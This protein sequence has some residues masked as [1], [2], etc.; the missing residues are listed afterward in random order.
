MKKR[1]RERGLSV[2]SVM[3]MAVTAAVL[4]M[5]LAVLIRLQMDVRVKDQ[6]ANALALSNELT[7]GVMNIPH[8]RVE[9]KPTQT[10]KPTAV[11]GETVTATP[12]P[13]AAPTAVPT[14]TPY[15]GSSF[16]VTAGGVMA[17]EK[18]V[19]LSC[20]YRDTKKYDMD[21][22]VQLL[23]GEITGD[24]RMVTLENLTPE[25]GK[26]NGLIAPEAA[27]TMLRTG[28]FNTVSL[29]FGKALDQGVDALSQTIHLA[30]NEGLRTIGAYHS[31]EER[32]VAQQIVELQGIRTAVMHYTAP[33]NL[34]AATKKKRNAEGAWL[35]PT[36]D[37]AAEDIAQA[38]EAGAQ[39]VIVSI[40][41]GKA[42]ATAPTKKQKEIAQ[43]LAN[44]GADV[45]LGA[46]SRVVQPIVWLTADR[47]AG[48]TC[49]TLCCYD[50]GGLLSDN[51]TNNGVAAMLLHFTVA[52]D[53]QRHV[54]IKDVCYTPTYIWHYKQDGGDHYRIINSGK[55]SPDG[56]SADLEKSKNNARISTGKKIANEEIPVRD[57][58]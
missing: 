50:L 7:V 20:Y 11:P 31:D 37:E 48:K 18:N 49:K 38:R 39:F 17:I 23:S 54:M 58:Q 12:A 26:A 44:A 51:R 47:G 34:T 16:E 36:V 57:A 29:G 15:A 53:A 45:I 2:G 22:I 14:A 52:S 5:M 9:A 42:G 24:L 10:V 28:G 46:G 25:D 8:E 55:A 6:P 43:Q 27:M 41:W 3:M 1:G 56:M 32:G 33:E 30:E 4:F 35:L 21:E 40:Y 13:T 19:R